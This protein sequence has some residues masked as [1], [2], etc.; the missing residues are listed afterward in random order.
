MQSQPPLD[1]AKILLETALENNGHI[2][3]C[4]I[5]Y[6]RANKKWVF[7]N[8]TWSICSKQFDS[9]DEALAEFDKYCKE[10]LDMELAKAS[11]EKHEPIPPTY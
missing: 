4:P 3:S 6:L 1:I 10:Y 8:E 11:G 7:W 9:F 2:R 5:E